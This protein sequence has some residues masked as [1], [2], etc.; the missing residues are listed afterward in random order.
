MAHVALFPHAGEGERRSSSA[1][2]QALS[3]QVLSGLPTVAR[4][5]DIDLQATA[6]EPRERGGGDEESAYEWEHVSS[7]LRSLHAV[8]K[9][10]AEDTSAHLAMMDA[11]VQQQLESLRVTV[12]DGEDRE[13]AAS[14]CSSSSADETIQAVRFDVNDLMGELKDSESHFRDVAKLVAPSMHK[15]QSLEARAAYFEAA[16]EVERRSQEAKTQA[17]RATSDALGAFAAFAV[18]VHTLPQEYTYIKQEAERRIAA[19]TN[20]L[21]TYAVEKLQSALE[22]IAWPVELT[23][24][25]LQSKEEELNEIAQS[26]SYLLTL[27]L[28]QQKIDSRQGFEDD[29][30]NANLWSMDC[31][32]DSILV[33]FRYHFERLESQT[34]RLAKP[35]WVFSHILS[36]VREHA[37]FLG[38]AISPELEK[39]KHVLDCSDAQVLLLRALI[40]AAQRK[41]RAEI[42]SLVAQKALFCH[43]LDEVLL[44]EQAIDDE[45]GYSS[46]A[47]T[48]RKVFPRCLDVFTEEMDIFIAWTSVDVAYAREVLANVIFE[49]EEKAW[50]FDGGD[51][52][53][54]WEPDETETNIPRCVLH[55]TSLLDFMCRRFAF[56]ASEEHRYLYLTQVHQLLLKDFLRE[57]ER[58]ARTID[59]HTTVSEHFVVANAAQYVAKVLS[60]WEQTSMFIE[61]TNKVVQ[62]EKSRSQVLKIHLEYS[63]SVLKNAAQAASIAVLAREEAAA[64]HH[65]I[66]GPGSL[67]GPA[68]AF[69][70]AYSVGSKTV[71][72]LLGRSEDVAVEETKPRE[73]QL[74]E[75]ALEEIE[76]DEALIF[77][78]SI[79]ERQIADFKS[80][81]RRLL[82]SA[83]GAVLS[84]FHRDIK[85]YTQRQDP[86]AVLQKDVS[87]ELRT[88]FTLLKCVFDSAKK[89]L[90]VGSQSHLSKDVASSVDELF[91]AAI[92]RSSEG[93]HQ[94]SAAHALTSMARDQF[95]FD[96]SVLTSIFESIDGK[97][98]KYLRRISDL[99]NLFN[100]EGSKVRELRNVLDN[101]G[102]SSDMEQVSTV[103]EV[104]RVHTMTPEQVFNVCSQIL[105]QD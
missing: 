55:F 90:V 12:A 32:L 2:L 104:C 93:F 98:K 18:Y 105:D 16:L 96:M 27:Q 21:K 75:P 41:F 17:M 88:S 36:Q 45:F 87:P 95:G 83:A 22:R 70:A 79:F 59:M 63:K 62:S 54:T 5:V 34:N 80:L 91:F 73:N 94:Q 49:N 102:G 20:D 42:P 50:E 53:A 8:T 92:T 100:L 31:L 76:D 44:F 6:G 7:A 48:N 28:S 4:R 60:A 39:Q 13:S 14:R 89:V 97:S 19:L 3:H 82:K 69:S 61:L 56:M 24:E 9:Q 51:G 81:H 43:T 33:R 38:R 23:A 99:R 86:A 68:A 11:Q 1:L 71:K 58:R 25:D 30:S 26:F 10:K 37:P 65:A 77:S 35:E 52:N 15:L 74:V 85:L 78:R 103:L 40:S 67:I 46:W 84:M 72:N 66:A 64:V 57:C 101:Q 47:N 29:G